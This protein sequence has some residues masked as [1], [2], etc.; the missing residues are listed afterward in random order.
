MI[1][2]PASSGRGSTRH[3]PSTRSRSRAP[4]LGQAGGAVA[5]S[6]KHVPS[7]NLALEHNVNAAARPA[8]RDDVSGP[9][10]G[11]LRL[12]DPDASVARAAATTKSLMV[13]RVRKQPGG[14]GMLS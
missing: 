2:S 12:S 1:A 3:L 13:F 8:R 10:R 11:D 4:S 9:A 5:P 6:S 14:F 7:R